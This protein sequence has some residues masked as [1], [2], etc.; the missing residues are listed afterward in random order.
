MTEPKQE[1]ASAQIKEVSPN[2]VL[3]RVFSEDDLPRNAMDKAQN[4]S[5]RC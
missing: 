3:K 5:L 4:N 1:R 2:K